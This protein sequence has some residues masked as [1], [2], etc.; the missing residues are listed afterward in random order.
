MSKASELYQEGGVPLIVTQLDALESMRSRLCAALGLPADSTPETVAEAVE[1]R[2]VVVPDQTEAPSVVAL[3]AYPGQRE[4]V[5]FLGAFKHELENPTPDQKPTS[6]DI[7]RDYFEHY[8]NVFSKDSERMAHGVGFKNGAEW[9]RQRFGVP[10]DR[11]LGDGMVEVEQKALE[12]LKRIEI[13]ARDFQERQR[14]LV[15]SRDSFG[16]FKA[17]LALE[18]ALRAN[19]GGA[20][21]A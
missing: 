12:R 9:H 8:A 4:H 21:H 19:Q 13:C 3:E 1:T 17:G 18:A 20:K 10:S 11:V 6:F 2:R 7:N 5:A 16:F 15:V 14:N